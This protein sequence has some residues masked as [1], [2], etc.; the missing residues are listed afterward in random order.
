MSETSRKR[1]RGRANGEGSFY[2]RADGMWIGAVTLPD[3]S[4]PTVSSKSQKAAKEK[5]RKLLRDIEDDKPITTG[6]GVTLAAYLDQWV[7][8]TLR[9]RVAAGKIRESTRL[10]YA[11]NIRLHITP[12]IGDE[13]LTKLTPVKLR[14]WIM[15]LQKKP[16]AR[17]KKTVNGE[18]PPVELLSDRTV[19]YCH[20]ILKTALNAARKEELVS[21]NVAELVEPPSG[22]SK[23][24]TYLT[25]NEAHRLFTAAIDDR[26]RVLW[27]TILGLGLRRGE[28]LSLRWEDL[29][30]EAGVANVGPSLQRLRGELDKETGRRRGRLA[31]VN[32]K[33]EGST[34]MVAIPRTLLTELHEYRKIQEVQRKKAKVWADAGWVFTTRYGTP[35]EPRNANR[36]W[37]ALCDRV[38]IEFRNGKRVRIHDLRHTAATWLHGQGVDM[39][40]IQGTLR[41]TQLSTTSEV[42]THLTVEVQTKAAES[43]DGALALLSKPHPQRR[44]VSK[45]RFQF[46]AKPVDAL[47]GQS[48]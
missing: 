30:L 40:A 26:W 11:D 33:T 14:T 9:Q 15:E 20:T 10:S 18:E 3:G 45:R 38:G 12:Y 17:K 37:T 32:G 4:R 6:K 46:P 27:L 34:T 16:S 43:M 22:K 35:I 39:K 25:Q 1:R 47:R 36:A 29:D 41:H 42:Y 5:W 31:V 23:R 2:Q 19:N 24:G 21:R 48:A 28:A 13:P 8:K 7:N 44:P